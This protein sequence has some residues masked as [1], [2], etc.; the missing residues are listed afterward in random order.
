MLVLSVRAWRGSELAF[1]VLQGAAAL[2]VALRLPGSR[3]ARA[4]ALT[5]GASSAAIAA[6]IILVADLPLRLFRCSGLGSRSRCHK[7]DR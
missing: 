1:A 7:E 6:A 2:A 4:L 5:V 3:P